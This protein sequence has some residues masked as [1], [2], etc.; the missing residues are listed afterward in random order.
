MKTTC[1][2]F[3]KPPRLDWNFGSSIRKLIGTRLDGTRR[4]TQTHGAEEARDRKR[5]CQATDYPGLTGLTTQALYD[6]RGENAAMLVLWLS[7][8]AALGYCLL[9]TF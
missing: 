1:C 9:A 5:E 2:N 3:D 6:H 7:A 8:L 4:F